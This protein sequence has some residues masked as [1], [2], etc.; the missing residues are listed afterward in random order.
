MTVGKCRQGLRH[1]LLYLFGIFCFISLVNVAGCSSRAVGNLSLPEAPDGF[2]EIEAAPGRSEACP[3]VQTQAAQPAN[4]FPIIQ[5][6]AGYYTTLSLTP[7]FSLELDHD[8]DYASV[9]SESASSFQDLEEVQAV[10]S[11]SEI[12]LAQYADWRG[13]RYRAGGSD[14]RGVDCSGLVHAV[15]RDAFDL[16][17]PRTS[18]ALSRIGAAVPKNDIRP[19]DLLYFI[20][21]GRKHVGVAVNDREFLHS[22]RRKGVILSKFDEYWKPRLLRVRRVLG[23]SQTRV[24]P[25]TGG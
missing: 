6:H 1:H 8:A 3:P 17:V 19:G 23:D 18:T 13:V 9:L 14:A 16:D 2:V 24:V 7:V 10:P 11:I 21:R 5:T 25:P 12:V 22:S 15:F 4:Q 20:D